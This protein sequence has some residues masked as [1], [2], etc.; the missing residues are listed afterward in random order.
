MFLSVT[1]SASAEEDKNQEIKLYIDGKKVEFE[2][3]QP[4]RSN[5][6]IMVPLRSLQKKLETEVKWNNETKQITSY[7]KGENQSTKVVYQLNS[8][9]IFHEYKYGSNKL[10]KVEKI[11]IPVE[12]KD[13]RSMV[14]I[15]AA[16]E[17]LGY[18]LKWSEEDN[19][20]QITTNKDIQPVQN[21]NQYDVYGDYTKIKPMELDLFY[22]TNKEREKAGIAPLAYDVENGEV[23]RIKSKDLH[24]NEYFAHE[25]PTLGSPFEMIERFGITYK[26]AGENLAAG[27]KKPEETMKGWMD[28]K[29]HKENILR[30]EFNRVGIGYYEGNKK[31]KRYY[32]Q[33]FT[34]K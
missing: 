1:S 33:I 34:D 10:T 22:L 18:I 32:T 26:S 12:Q 19:E 14:P 24:D 15:A 2:D 23:A 31:Y 7:K 28:S 6:V 25:S 8:N 29:G 16:T 4:T 5:N 9:Y 20:I 30:E 11:E 17:S 27:F 21:K 3:V 13:N